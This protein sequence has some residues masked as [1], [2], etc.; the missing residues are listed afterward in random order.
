MDFLKNETL[1]EKIIKPT[2]IA[3][4]KYFP[5]AFLI[6]TLFCLLYAGYIG[7]KYYLAYKTGDSKKIEVQM[8]LVKRGGITIAVMYIVFILIRVLFACIVKYFGI[9]F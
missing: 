2:A 5:K 1:V 7:L 9:T 4:K 8:H 3:I 6:L